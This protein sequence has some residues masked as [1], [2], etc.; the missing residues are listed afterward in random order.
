MERK[1]NVVWRGNLQQGQ[2]EIS[3]ESGVMNKVPYSLMRRFGND[4][5][6]NPEELIAAAHSSCFTM[7][8]AAALTQQNFTPESLQVSASVSIEK[9]GADW[10][11]TH[12][13]LV[14]HAKIPGIDSNKFK[15]IAEDAKNNCPVSRLLDT[16]ISLEANLDEGEV[17]A[18]H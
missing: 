3:T 18:Q 6:T 13:N 8:L 7:A 4:P 16:E 9:N 10:V 17:H 12:S 5:G 1:A 15:S 2:G 14:L 11:I